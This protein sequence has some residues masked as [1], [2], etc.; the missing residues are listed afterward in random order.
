M[1][2]ASSSLPAVSVILVCDHTAGQ[3]KGWADVRAAL[4]A[5]SRQD[6]DETAQ[7]LFFE[8]ECHRDQIP[9]DLNSIL[10]ALQVHVVPD[11]SA[12]ALKNAAVRATSADIV[13][14]L[15][16]DC[17]PDR[18]WLTRLIKT[19]RAHPEAA[20]VSGRTVYPQQSFSVRICALL[21]RSY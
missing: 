14:I 5:L 17:Q 8:S 11:Y 4:T 21:A 7:F 16:A 1:S 6:F 2:T 15:D 13:A 19:L 3:P 10:P 20:A 9:P 18:N 12:N